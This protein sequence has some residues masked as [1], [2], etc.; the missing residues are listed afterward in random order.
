MSRTDDVLAAID[1]AVR[2]YGISDDA[3]RWTPPGSASCPAAWL[4]AEC[5]TD[6]L[7]TWAAAA[8]PTILSAPCPRCSRPL[9]AAISRDTLL[10]LN[11]KFF[12]CG[13]VLTVRF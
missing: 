7:R 4:R 9:D 8:G 2:D 13:C 5:T 6:E 1:H 12:P 10:A 11:I 3:M